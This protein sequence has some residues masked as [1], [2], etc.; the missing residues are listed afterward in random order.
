MAISNERAKEL[1]ISGE[2]I[3]RDGVIYKKISALVF[4]VGEGLIDAYAEILDRNNNSV[5]ICPLKWLDE[6][7]TKNLHSTDSIDNDKI[8][9]M[10]N[11]CKDL[12]GELSSYIYR[13]RYDQAQG[14]INN[15]LRNLMRVDG[16]MGVFENIE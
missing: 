5:V 3:M 14:I 12:M 8:I 13:K 6:V 16:A 11:K 15:L 1:L 2:H 7:D 4:R 10:Y 9:T